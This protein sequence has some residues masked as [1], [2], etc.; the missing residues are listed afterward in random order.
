MV[1]RKGILFSTYLHAFNLMEM[2]AIFFIML[3]YILP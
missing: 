3:S 1:Q 2:V